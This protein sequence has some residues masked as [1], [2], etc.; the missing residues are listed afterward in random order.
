[1]LDAYD[2]ALFGSDKE[3]GREARV[4]A[5][6]RTYVDRFAAPVLITTL[7]SDTRTPIRPI[8]LFVDDMRA[9]WKRSSSRSSRAAT[10]AHRQGALG[11]DGRVVAG[12]R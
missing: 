7:E 5:S 3:E 9:A 1:M 2:I 6:P 11:R 12:V 4:I 8:R 10:P